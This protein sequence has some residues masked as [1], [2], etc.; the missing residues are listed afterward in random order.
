MSKDDD[1]RFT[2]EIAD[3]S[4]QA[5]SSNNEATARRAAQ[6]IAAQRARQTVWP[7]D[8]RAAMTVLGRMFPSLRDAAGV[9]P[10]DVDAL[11]GWLNTGAYS[12]A[13]R[14][15]GLFLLSVWNGDDWCA[16]GLKVRRPAYK[17]LR[18]I[19]RF[20]FNDA[21]ACWDERNRAAAL[22]WLTCPFWP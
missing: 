15:A 2:V 7:T 4:G 8:N 17:E 9:D 10:W 13:E 21:W 16:Y 11:V 3:G 6:E 5:V 22:A 14:C 18:R 19:G 12:K 1:Y 20:D